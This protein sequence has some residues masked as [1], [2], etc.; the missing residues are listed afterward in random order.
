MSRRV[1][2]VQR[3][4]PLGSPVWPRPRGGRHV[5]QSRETRAPGGPPWSPAHHT[6][7]RWF[8]APARAKADD[9]SS[10]ALRCLR[11]GGPSRLKTK[12]VT[13]VFNVPALRACAASTCHLELERRSKS[14]CT[15]APVLHSLPPA[16]P[17]P[18][19]EA[20]AGWAPALAVRAE[21][22]PHRCGLCALHPGPSTLRRLSSPL[23]TEGGSLP[24][25]CQATRQ[26]REAAV[27]RQEGGNRSSGDRGGDADAG[28]SCSEI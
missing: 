16:C 5:E 17:P 23:S 20:P 19:P 26:K 4:S 15:H 25:L 2:Q 1:T 8:P 11:A 6:P 9:G 12:T 18:P 24:R 10:S 27:P 22:G 28:G 21:L 3:G 14:K 7:P 13:W